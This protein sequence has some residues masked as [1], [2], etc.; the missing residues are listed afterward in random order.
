MH[1]SALV[2]VAANSKW[3]YVKERFFEIKYIW[4]DE[5]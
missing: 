1:T 2:K 4:L 3:N 5:A